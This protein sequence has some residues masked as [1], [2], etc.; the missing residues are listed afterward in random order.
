M[1]VCCLIT[2][3]P[4]CKEYAKNI[5]GLEIYTVHRHKRATLKTYNFFAVEQAFLPVHD[6]GQTEMSDPPNLINH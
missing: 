5:P 2:N 4:Q 1:Y 3:L 6:K